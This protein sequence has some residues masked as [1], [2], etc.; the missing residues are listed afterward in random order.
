MLISTDELRTA[1]DDKGRPVGTDGY[2]ISGLATADEAA[3]ALGISRSQIYSMMNTGELPSRRF[4]RARR[5][6][7]AIIRELIG[8]D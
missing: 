3:V 2:P 8:V 4:G 1:R 5:I 6:P 7:W